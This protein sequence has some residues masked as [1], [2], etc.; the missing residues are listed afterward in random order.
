MDS[1]SGY[2]RMID[3]NIEYYNINA[4][5]FIAGTQNADMSLWRD[6]FESYVADGGRILDAGC[7]SGRDSKAFLQHGYSVVA[8]DAS[9]EMRKAAARFIGQEVWQMK[10]D[11]ISF[12]E[13]FDGIWA[14]ASLL[15]VSYDELPDILQKLRKALVPGGM[16]YVS[17]KYG[18][19]SMT[20][21]E[22]TF[23]NFTEASVTELLKDAH[24]EV[25]ECG[26]TSDVRE[27]RADEKWINAIARKI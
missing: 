22:R 3:N 5:S 19:G 26:I 17:F 13:E 8:F 2:I 24:F 7:G 6:K 10:F 18:E 14:C 25:K 1:E 27:G 23:S 4:E 11:E 9:R 20:K 12:D 21:G 15:H 16:I